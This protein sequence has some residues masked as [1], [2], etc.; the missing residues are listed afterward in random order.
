MGE[1]PRV[2][3]NWQTND[4]I[5][6]EGPSVVFSVTHTATAGELEALR[7]LDPDRIFLG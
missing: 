1:F 3:A 2:T 5:R 6:G 4:D 7:R